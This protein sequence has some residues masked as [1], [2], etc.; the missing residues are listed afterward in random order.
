[1]NPTFLRTQK[2]DEN[3]RQGLAGAVTASIPQF[4]NDPAL[5]SL[6]GKYYGQLPREGTPYSVLVTDVHNPQIMILGHLYGNVYTDMQSNPS[7]ERVY[8]ILSD[9]A[10]HWKIITQDGQLTEKSHQPPVPELTL[11]NLDRAVIKA[12]EEF[13]NGGEYG[14]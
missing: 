1:M 5:F 12:G 3:T 9:N 2:L 8:N 7:T 13:L 10:G 14:K 4:L 11:G 6:S